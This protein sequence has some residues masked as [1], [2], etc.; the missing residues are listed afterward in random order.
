MEISSKDIK[1]KAAELGFDLCGIAK[2]RILSECEPVIKEWI[3][4]GCHDGMKYLERDIPK[5][6]NPSALFPGARSVVVTG[7]NYFSENMQKA[8]GSPVISRY[9]YGIDYHVVISSRLKTLL[10]WIKSVNPS[11]SGR[12]TVDSAPILE[13]S[14]ARE[15]GLGYPGRNSIIINKKVGSFFFIGTIILNLELEYDNP[16][17]E[18]LCGKCMICIR[19]C[20][21]RAINDNRTIDARKC[22]SNLTIENRGPVPPELRP[23]LGLRI[24]GCDKCQEVC[25]WNKNATPNNI[26]EFKLS[27]E[28]AGMSLDDWRTLS[29]DK[30]LRLFGKSPVG[31][32]GY[33]KMMEN[34]EA[35]TG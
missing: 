9:A 13:K 8:A 24:F 15:A 18:D 28:I 1:E 5:R 31:R 32:T 6:L 4:K 27:D 14:W 12:I 10:K 17:T 22:I 29:R 23:Y 20:P 11:A 25:P 3:M 33:E 16:A 30:F 35:A 19:E 34:I 7:L 2:A 21:T 26:P